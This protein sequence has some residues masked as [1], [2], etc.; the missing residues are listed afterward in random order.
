MARSREHLSGVLFASAAALLWSTGGLFIKLA[1]L[2][3]LG[4]AGVRSLITAL[5]F[6]AVFRPK[7][8]EARW[9]TALAYAGMILTFV[10]ATKLTT[11]ANAIFLQYTGPAYVLLFSPWVLGEKLER[12]DIVCV[13]LSIAGMSL[14]LVDKV[15]AG[16]ALGN[17][18]GVASGLF[19]GL[20]VLF[21]RRDALR[22]GSG[23]LPSSTMGNLL[24]A[25]VG[26]PFALGPLRNVW[27]PMDVAS[28]K[29]IGGLLWLGVVQMGVA[30]VFFD[31]ALRRV[32][33]AEASLLCMLEPIF[34]P[35]W[36]VLGTGERPST[37]ALI[38]GAVVLCAVVLRTAWPAK[39]D[40]TT[41]AKTTDPETAA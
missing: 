23:S 11:A 9:T 27:A 41:I 4:V 14:L 34:S 28:A 12:I 7:L 13:L 5:F 26:V 24:A 31:R 33:A 15:E 39:L 21:L 19:F 20:S 30:Y 3:G 32:K 1:P 18:L 16:A 8:R 10:T 36:V 17:L 35:L 6:L 22:G 37:W 38:G 25:L 2:P 40:K 29:A